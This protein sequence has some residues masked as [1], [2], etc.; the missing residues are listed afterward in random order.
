MTLYR[1]S[2]QVELICDACDVAGPDG[3]IDESDFEI[4]LTDAKAAGWRASRIDSQ[5]RHRCPDCIRMSRSIQA[6]PDA[7]AGLFG[8]T[9]PERRKPQ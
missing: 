5:W 1:D 4:L 7:T 6:Q 3:P 9:L 2:C 8:D